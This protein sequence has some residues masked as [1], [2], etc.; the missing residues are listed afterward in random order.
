MIRYLLLG[1]SFSVSFALVSTGNLSPVW[2]QTNQTE[3]EAR[4]NSSTERDSFSSDLGQG[5]NPFDLIHRMNNRNL[6]REEYIRRQQGELNSAA[7][8]FRQKQ[9][10]LL[11]EN[12]N[13]QQ[14]SP[15]LEGGKN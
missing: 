4:P 11:Q 3:I 1:F 2:S 9:K 13:S 5:L 12:N 6:S 10:Q 15:T 14:Q 7:S 8:E